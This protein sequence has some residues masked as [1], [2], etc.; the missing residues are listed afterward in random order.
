MLVTI[1]GGL[2]ATYQTQQRATLDIIGRSFGVITI[3][4]EKGEFVESLSNKTFGEFEAVI[5]NTK[6]SRAR[7]DGTSFTKGE[8]PVCRSLDG[9]VSV[10]G[11]SCRD[12]PYANEWKENKPICPSTINLHLWF[13][14]EQRPV[15]LRARG[16][17]LS[18]VKGY[19][20]R[21]EQCRLS[22]P[23][24]VVRFSLD[25]S[26]RGMNTYYVI[27]PEDKEI[28]EDQKRFQ[29]VCK[30]GEQFSGQFQMKDLDSEDEAEVSESD[31]PY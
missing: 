24:V 4:Q 14:A 15:I 9:K 2:P 18:P 3:D 23:Q 28:I 29:E 5:L 17:S 10:E 26:E 31:V 12:C 16:S 27:H 19:L 11:D 21:M 7:F 6:I 25:K 13:I 20:S 22:Y 1:E 8:K 30:I